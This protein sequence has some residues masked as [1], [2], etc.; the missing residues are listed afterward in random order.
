MHDMLLLWRKLHDQLLLMSKTYF[1]E[2]RAKRKE[3]GLCLSCGK[4]PAPCDSCR[5]RNREYMRRKR[6]GIPAEEKTRQWHSKRHYY[7]KYKFGITEQQYD[8]MLKTQN[9]CCAI[10]KS[11]TSG[12]KRSTRLSIDHCH[13]SGEIRGL[14]CSSCNK[15]IGLLKDSPDL[16]RSA[17]G[18][19][20]KHVMK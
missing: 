13:K 11:T 6:A 20:I 19:L 1:A 4:H 17:I 15:A 8:E 18:Y 7:L 12:D 9:Y 2:L 10:C 14:L 16:L 3:L 5:L